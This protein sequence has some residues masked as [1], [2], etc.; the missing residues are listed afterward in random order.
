VGS[1]SSGQDVD[2]FH[3]IGWYGIFYYLKVVKKYN[4][5][6]WYK[7]LFT[8]DYARELLTALWQTVKT[9]QPPTDAYASNLRVHYAT[10]LTRIHEQ[11]EKLE[12]SSHG[13]SS[14]TA[15]ILKKVKQDLDAGDHTPRTFAGKLHTVR[16]GLR[17]SGHG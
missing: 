2:F 13:G 8:R 7:M 12:T 14:S 9:F 11:L 3:D 10:V 1:L 15:S 6:E 5:T 17:S 4:I 16:L